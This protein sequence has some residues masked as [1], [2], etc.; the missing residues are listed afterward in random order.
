MSNTDKTNTNLILPFQF[1]PMPHLNFGWGVR[2]NFLK[3]LSNR[4]YQK[5][6]LIFIA[7]SNT[8]LCLENPLPR[9]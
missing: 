7:K 4:N 6:L 8:I 9:E 3:S 5:P 2:N 1:A